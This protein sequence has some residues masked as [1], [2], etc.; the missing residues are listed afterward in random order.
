MSQLIS[1]WRLK[2]K[3]SGTVTL[4]TEGCLAFPPEWPVQK[5]RGGRRV[6]NPGRGDRHPGLKEHQFRPFSLLTSRAFPCLGSV[7]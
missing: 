7:Q 4:P 1:S 6:R 5:N 2:H 3:T